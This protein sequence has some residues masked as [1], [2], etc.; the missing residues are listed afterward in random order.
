[1]EINLNKIENP[2][3]GKQDEN[4]DKNFTVKEVANFLEETPNVIRNWFKE[5]RNY[6]P[7][8]KNSNGYNVYKKD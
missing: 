8:E 1:M 7:H 6:T 3:E 5:F 4:L 2:G